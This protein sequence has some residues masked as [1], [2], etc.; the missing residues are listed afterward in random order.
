MSAEL[1]GTPTG[2]PDGCRE[3]PPWRSEANVAFGTAQRP[4]PTGDALSRREWLRASSLGFGYLA[5]AAL[6]AE[7]CRAETR[8]P[9]FAPRAKN[10]IFLFMDGGVSHVDS[11]DPKPELDRRD[12][13][14]IGQWK[15]T[16]KSQSV[17]PTRAWKKSPWT[18]AQ[19]GDSGLPV[20][21]LFPHLATC[22]DELC[23]I[24]A[25]T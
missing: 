7:Q 3:R 18:F 8:A 15:P 21:A 17:N 20:S 13:Q 25:P 16:P 12:G 5:W 1:I 22:I 23:V 2:F 19:H 9:H 6:Q 14:K 11:F 24:R 10:V 4:F